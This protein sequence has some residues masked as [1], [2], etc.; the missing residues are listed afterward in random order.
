MHRDRY[1]ASSYV[2]YQLAVDGRADWMD[3]EEPRNIF[4]HGTHH[5]RHND[6]VSTAAL[7]NLRAG[8]TVAIKP[9]KGG[10]AKNTRI[11]RSHTYF[12]GYYVGR[13]L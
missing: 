2:H 9:F 7:I 3:G 6:G 10:G 11:Y 1:A 4:G 8:Q 12:A 13:P 5:Q